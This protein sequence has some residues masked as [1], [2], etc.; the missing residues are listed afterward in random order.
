MPHSSTNRVAKRSFQGHDGAFFSEVTSRDIQFTLSVKNCFLGWWWNQNFKWR[1]LARIWTKSGFSCLHDLPNSSSVPTTKMGRT[2]SLDW[3]NSLVLLPSA[4]CEFLSVAN[5]T[6]AS[7]ATSTTNQLLCYFRNINPLREQLVLF[8]KYIPLLER[9]VLFQKYSFTK[10]EAC[11]ISEIS[12]HYESSF[13]YFRN[14][15]HYERPVLFQ[16]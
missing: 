10:R 6:S 16:K 14:I 2:W 5:S 12:I 13:Y 9:L 8:W 7:S 11:A 4:P 3:P 15:F 1:I